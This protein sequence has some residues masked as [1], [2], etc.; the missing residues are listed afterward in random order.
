MNLCRRASIYWTCLTVSREGVLLLSQSIRVHRLGEP[1]CVGGHLRT[2]KLTVLHV[3]Y[4]LSYIY[5]AHS[6]YMWHIRRIC[7]I[8]ADA[9]PDHGL[10]LSD[11]RYR[12]VLRTWTSKP[13]PESGLECRTCDIFARQRHLNYR[14]TSY[15]PERVCTPDVSGEEQHLRTMA[16]S[17]R[18]RPI[19]TDCLTGVTV[20]QV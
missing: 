15:V 6:S 9:P 4:S 19:A 10:Q 8:F 12:P 1:G 17:C 20:F 5:M 11:A 18:M 2:M 3:A 7:G 16:L 14:Y 13:R